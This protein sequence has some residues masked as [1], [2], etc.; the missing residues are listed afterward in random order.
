[1]MYFFMLIFLPPLLPFLCLYLS[2]PFPLPFFPFLFPSFLRLSLSLLSFSY[3]PSLLS[4]LLSLLSSPFPFS[5]L[6]PSRFSFFIVYPFL[7]LFHSSWLLVFS[8]ITS[9]LFILYLL[10][11]PLFLSLYFISLFYF[12]LNKP[13]E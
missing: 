4:L 5:F 13:V 3:L 10:R 1:M 9:F 7:F 6:L 12:Y 11:L 2:S 8:A